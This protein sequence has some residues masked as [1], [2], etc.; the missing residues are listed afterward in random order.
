MK[1]IE[2]FNLAWTEQLLQNSH[3]GILVVDNLRKNLFV[4]S[5]LCEMFGYEEKELLVLDAR[6]FHVTEETFLNFGKKAF[7]FVLEGKPVGMDYQ[8]KKKDGTVFWVHIAGDLVEGQK[9]VL[10]TMVD[11]SKRK[12]LEMQYSEQ[13]Q[14]IDQIQ[15]GIVTIDLKGNATSWNSGAHKIL[16]YTQDDVLNKST[17]MMY[18][19]EDHEARE[20]NIKT[21]LKEGVFRADRKL[22]AKDGIIVDTELTGSILKNVDNVAIGMVGYFKDISIR[23]KAQKELEETNYNLQQYMDVIDKIDIGIFV[24][25]D[26]FRVRYMNN[27]MIDWFGDQTNKTCYSSVAGLDEPCSYCKL[28]EVIR[29]NQKVIYE[30]TTPDGQ[31]FDIVSTAIKNADGTISKME[32]I[33]NVTD[34][35]MAEKHLQDQR[36]ELKYQAHHDSLTGLPNRV[37]FNDRLEQGMKKVKRLGKKLALFFIDLDHFK[38]INDSLGHPIGDRVL[39]ETTSRL[40]SVIREEDSL[41]RLGGDE[42]TVVIEGLERS[43]DAS[44]FANKVLEVLSE[45]LLIDNNTLYVSSSIGISI[46]PDDSNDAHDLLKF[47]DSAMYKAKDEGRNNFQFYSSEMTELAF[48]RVV[49]ET[50]LRQAIQNEEFIVYYQPQVNAKTNTIVGMEALVRWNHPTIGLVPPIKFIPLAES[51]GLIIDIDDFVMKT[52]MKQ[53]RE[54][55]G[56]GLNPGT[57]SLNLTVGQL[58]TKNIVNKMKNMIDDIGCQYAN[59]ELEVTE[60]NIMKDP[61]EAIKTLKQINDLGINLAVDD[62]GT[63]YSS[64]SY[65]KRLPISKLKIDQSFVRDL[66]D[67]EEDAAIARAVIALASSLNLRVIAEGVETKAQK[68]FLLQNGCEKIQGYYYSKPVPAEDITKLLQNGLPEDNTN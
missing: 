10:W 64:L 14:I 17:E 6:V 29:E 57:L 55:Y 36:E 38:E 51:T 28:H 9:E 46:Y 43:Q 49:M 40:H 30:P 21:L 59:I 42:F 27:T 44:S 66:P 13:A 22:I 58:R 50:S 54:W 2:K 63:G 5:H 41:A 4:N 61:H 20:R 15:D 31:S 34:K 35:K 33:R 23:K 48:E 1:I 7:S 47:A 67:N 37:L 16:G 53:F 25:D 45:P 52:A 62:F 12:L 19:P 56:L 26:D 65:L 24:V 18:L 68:D 60:S 3:I 39:K 11:I 32:V 8:F